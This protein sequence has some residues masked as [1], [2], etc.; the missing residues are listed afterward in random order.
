MLVLDLS[1][2]DATQGI[3]QFLRHGTWLVTKAIALASVEVVDIRDRAD[4]SSC[5]LAYLVYRRP[6][7]RQ[8]LLIRRQARS[9]V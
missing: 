2:L 7:Y 6:R 9:T 3:K 5:Y 8:A 4:H 1:V